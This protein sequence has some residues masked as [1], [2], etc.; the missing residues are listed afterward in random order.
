MQEIIR[1]KLWLL[2]EGRKG[3]K[4]VGVSKKQR[5]SDLLEVS[6][7]TFCSSG[8]PRVANWKS[9]WTFGIEYP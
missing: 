8:G 5:V 6:Y 9:I 7:I 2:F 1:V 4:R 3:R